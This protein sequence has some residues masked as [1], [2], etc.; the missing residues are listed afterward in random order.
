[1]GFSLVGFIIVV[2]IMIPNLLYIKYPPKELPTDLKDVSILYTILER[3]GQG[4]FFIILI[5]SKNNYQDPKLNIL[6]LLMF[7]CIIV[8]YYLWLRYALRGTYFSQLFEPLWIIP[9]PM[10]IFPV[11]AFGFAALWG[12]SIYLGAAVVMFAIGH[13]TNSWNNYKRS[14][15]KN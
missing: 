10:A 15:D 8:Y 5:V 13:F 2:V 6:F 12:S 4:A 14:K 1:M 9:I 7:I 11:L 3:S